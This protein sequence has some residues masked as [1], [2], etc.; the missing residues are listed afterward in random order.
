MGAI[1]FFSFT[2]F[3]DEQPFW[4]QDLYTK[5]IGK[6]ENKTYEKLLTKS[7][8]ANSEILR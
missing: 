3:K 2:Y 4:K 7:D 1:V 5:Y 6:I 8:Q